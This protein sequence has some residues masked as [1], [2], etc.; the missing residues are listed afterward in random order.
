[1][2][3]PTEAKRALLVGTRTAYVLADPDIW[4]PAL[5][6]AVEGVGFEVS[7]CGALHELFEVC[8][9]RPGALL[10]LAQRNAP[11]AVRACRVIRGLQDVPMMVV[12]PREGDLIPVLDAGADDAVVARVEAGV[13]AARVRALIRRAPPAS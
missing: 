8:R 3:V 5:G 4:S 6:E 13:F 1:M 9:E 12:I 10:V 7:T 2:T 11:F